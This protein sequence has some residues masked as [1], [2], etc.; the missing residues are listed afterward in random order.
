MG[1]AEPG[2]AADEQR[3]VGEPGQ[4]GDGQ[5]GGVGEPVGVADHELVEREARVEA[6][7]RERACR[8]GAAPG[9]SAGA[10]RRD[11]L[12][13]RAG[14]EHGLAQAASS[15]AKRS[16]RPRRGSRPAPRRRAFA[17]EL[18]A[19]RAARATDVPGGVADRAAHLGADAAPG[20]G[21]VVVGH[22]RAEASSGR[23]V[24]GRRW[25]RGLAAGPGGEHS[26]GPGPNDGPW[27]RARKSRGIVR[28]VGAGR[29]A[30]DGVCT[31]LC[32][33]AVVSC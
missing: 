31:G 32:E 13:A 4:L 26:N 29:N 8:G 12:H 11:E 9:R 5:R 1:L 28:A 23:E 22:G 18:R 25:E 21:D 33:R 17:L 6:R 15:R 19:R 24:V 16:A 10:A 27:E 7:R 20:C 14:P 30:V 3:V 2:R